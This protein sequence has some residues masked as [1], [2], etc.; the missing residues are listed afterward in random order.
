MN[1]IDKFD[2]EGYFFDVKW[3]SR[4]RARILVFSFSSLAEGRKWKS[5]RH[6]GPDV[7][8]QNHWGGMDVN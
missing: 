8:R 3:I 6:L 1:D 5:G 4:C 7:W 2:V